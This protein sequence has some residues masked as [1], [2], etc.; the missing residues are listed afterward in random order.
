[1]QPVQRRLLGRTRKLSGAGTNRVEQRTKV[2]LPL[3]MGVPLV[4]RSPSQE[5][6]HRRPSTR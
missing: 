6:P 5:L 4:T 3:L 1:M 2:G